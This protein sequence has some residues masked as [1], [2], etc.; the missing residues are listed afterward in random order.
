MH[1]DWRGMGNGAG[2]E[3]QPRTPWQAHSPIQ[4]GSWRSL[5]FRVSVHRLAALGLSLTPLSIA[6]EY[7]RRTTHGCAY[8]RLVASRI[9]RNTAWGLSVTF[10]R[11]E[12]RRSV[13]MQCPATT[14]VFDHAQ[15]IIGCVRR[16][17]HCSH[18]PTLRYEPAESASLREIEREVLTYNA[19]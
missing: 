17:L 12:T 5:A 9:N 8:G 6:T 15:C 19:C 3:L 11:E 13:L 2:A 16:T 4:A 7:S 14:P 1:E 18:V 10:K